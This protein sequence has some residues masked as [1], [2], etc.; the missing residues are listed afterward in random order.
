MNNNFRD[1]TRTY[2][3]PMSIAPFLI[4]FCCA[5]NTPL[6][7]DSSILING[8][9]VLIGIILIH[10]ASNLFD[11]YIDVKM[12]LK[13]GLK[14]NEINFKSERKARAILNGAYSLKQAE[15]ILIA[16]V[17][18]G[19]LI[20]LYFVYLRGGVIFAYM[21]IALLL[22]A[23][24]PISSKYGL[25]EAVVGVVFGPLLINA[26]YCALTGQF[27][28]Q[29]FNL[30]FASGIIT[31]ILL[32]THSLMD[33]EFDLPSGKKTLPV[34]LENKNLTVNAISILISISFGILIYTT[35]KYGLTKLVL[36]AI[37][38]SLPVS[39][40]LILSLYDYIQI[41]NVKFIPEWYLGIMEDWDEILK[42][43]YA[44]FMYRFYL[45]RNLSA[46]FNTVVAIACLI[47]FMPL[48]RDDF[49]GLRFIFNQ[50]F[51]F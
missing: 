42:N 16:L 41:K 36:F 19:F 23:F 35:V 22:S 39:I 25:S 14:L 44:Y 32:I 49:G 2:T 40:K 11:D 9:L 50:F 4:A 20:G 15:N 30:S 51:I 34:L 37:L 6:F 7:P 26:S 29:V 21:L 12:Q 38:F 18:A 43:N 27:D 28:P 13:K 3:L 1:L 5:V 8:I 33:F 47:G 10:M 17:T 48:G 45:A 46:I 24:Y 31:T